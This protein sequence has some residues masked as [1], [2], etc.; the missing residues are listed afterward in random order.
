MMY[1]P[2]MHTILEMVPHHIPH[3]LLVVTTDTQCPCELP[4]DVYYNMYC[5]ILLH[6]YM[7]VYVYVCNAVM[8]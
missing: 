5:Y 7:P 2:F 4:Q 3:L 8:L 6:C 1:F